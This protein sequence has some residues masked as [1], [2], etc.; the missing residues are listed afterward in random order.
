MIFTPYFQD[1]QLGGCKREILDMKVSIWITSSELKGLAMLRHVEGPS[2]GAQWCPTGGSW[3]SF[4]G[5]WPS[6]RSDR[7]FGYV[8]MVLIPIPAIHTS[9]IA[10]C[11]IIRRIFTG[12]L[13]YAVRCRPISPKPFKKR[14]NMHPLNTNRNCCTRGCV[15]TRLVNFEPAR[16]LEK[17]FLALE[18]RFHPSHF[19]GLCGCVWILGLVGRTGHKQRGDE[20]RWDGNVVSNGKS[21]A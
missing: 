9:C 13:W 2:L 6:L 19:R 16:N 21:T 11:R 15:T 18:V 10:M 8:C 12:E 3:P 4:V 5:P 7:C 20:R 14:D 1:F 17:M